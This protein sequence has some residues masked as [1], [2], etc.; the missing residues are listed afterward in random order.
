MERGHALVPKEQQSWECQTAK[1]KNL[2]LPHG[3]L[4]VRRKAGSHDIS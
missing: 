2:V 1:V 4:G 3:D